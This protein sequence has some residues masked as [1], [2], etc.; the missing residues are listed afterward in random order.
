MEEYKNNTGGF[1]ANKIANDAISTPIDNMLSQIQKK[2]EVNSPS[3]DLQK[4]LYEIENTTSNASSYNYGTPVEPHNKPSFYEKNY[5]VDELYGRLAG[6]G[7][8]VKKFDTYTPNIDNYE[9]AAQNQSSGEKWA[10]GTLKF[11]S[12]T[13]NAVVGGTVGVVYGVGAF[14]GD[15]EVSSL[16][17]NDFS[18]K[19]ADLDTKLNYQLPNYYTKQENE[20]GVFSQMGTANFWSDKFLGGLS[21][22]VGAIVSEGIWAYATG[23]T[24]LATLGARAGA[25]LA[26]F[27]RWG[28]EGIGEAGVIAGMSKFKGAIGDL[29]TQ[30]LRAGAQSKSLAIAGGQAGE[31]LSTVGFM[32]RSAGYEASVEALQFKRESE[33]NFYRNFSSLNGREPNA[34]DI[35]LFE[36]DL[37]SSANAVFGVNIAIVGSSNLVTMGH[38]LDIKSPINTG[39]AKFID[40]KAFGYGI[41]KA[42][43]EVLE[44]STKQKIA[45][46]VFDYVVKPGFTEGLFEEGLQGVTTKTANKWIEH[47]YNPKYTSDNFDTMDAMY[48]AMGEQYGTEKGW[49]DNMLG[50]LIG[51]AGASVNVRSEQAAKAEELK[52]E[53]AVGKTFGT[54]LQAS[55]L[56][57]RVQTANR[58]A[59]FSNEAKEEGAKGNISKSALA[60]KS[61]IL[62]YINAEQTLGKST[63][64]IV[65]SME[66]SLNLITPSQWKEIGIEEGKIE[67][68]K[69]DRLTEL[70]SLATQWATNKKYTQYMLGRKLVGEQN[71]DSTLLEQSLGSNFS[72][73][74]QI[75]EALTWQM[76]IGENAHTQMRDAQSVFS[77]ELGTEYSKSLDLVSKLKRQTSNRQGQ[78]TKNSKIH[79]ELSE[80]RARITQEVAALDAKPKTTDQ[81]KPGLEPRVAL[82]QRLLKINAR[83]DTVTAEMNTIA[84]EMTKTDNYNKEVG[85]LDLSSQDLTGTIIS[86]KDLLDLD[87]NVAKFKSVLASF[88]ENNPQKSQYLNDLLDEYS[89]AEE[90]FLQS[91]VTQ[92]VLVDKAFKMANISSWIGS[93]VNGKKA[94]NENT[95][96]W[97]QDAIDTYSK[98]KAM[99]LA[100]EEEIST[101]V[102]VEEAVVDNTTAKNKTEKVEPKEI[103]S[104]VEIYKQKIED[105]LK[106]YDFGYIGNISDILSLE[107]PTQKDVAEYVRL[108]K[109]GKEA[110]TA[111]EKKLQNWKLLNSTMDSDNASIVET[112]K[113]I[114]QLEQEVERSNTKDEITPQDTEDFKNTLQGKNNINDYGLGINPLGSVTVQ[115]PQGTSVYRFSHLSAEFLANKVGEETIT[116]NNEEVP[117]NTKLNVGDIVVVAGV[118][119]TYLAQGKM[120]IT[121]NDY[122]VASSIF[123]IEVMDTKA[124]G[125]SYSDVYTVKGEDMVKLESSYTENIKPEK[126]YNSKPG[127]KLTLV[128]DNTDGFNSGKGVDALN[129]KIYLKDSEGNLIQVL[130]AH[131]KVEIGDKVEPQFLALRQQA[132]KTWVEAGKPKNMDLG[133]TVEVEDIFMGSPEMNI[134]NGEPTDMAISQEAAQKVEA[135][136]YILNGEITVNREI[137]DIDK[138]YVGKLSKNNSD[139]K[140]PI[141]IFKKGAYYVAFP[142]SMVKVVESKLSDLE[143]ILS[144]NL[145]VQEQVFKINDLIIKN[146]ITTPKVVFSDLNSDTKIED[147]KDAFENNT[148][149]K[150]ADELADTGYKTEDLTKDAL[151]KIDLANLDQTIKDV[152]VRFNVE[153]IRLKKTKK[154]VENLK[155]SLAEKASN[156]AD[157]LYKALNTT[158]GVE[159]MKDNRFIDIILDGY[160]TYKEGVKVKYFA[161]N[162]GAATIISKNGE[163]IYGEYQIGTDLA[164]R[165]GL[166]ILTEAYKHLFVESPNGRIISGLNKAGKE[167]VTQDMIEKVKEVFSAL[168]TLKVQEKE[169]EE[170]E[171]NIC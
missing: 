106:A 100:R 119:F 130:K 151:I 14:L 31:L 94:M 70:Q 165:R 147:L 66:K 10:N 18:N 99:S 39:L 168:E 170:G 32:G 84:E 13:L 80:E 135:T 137:A 155:I 49:K 17:D 55:L 120:E 158:K 52:Y 76:T 72:K 89:Q 34:E 105:A 16:Y 140:V 95:Q 53:V 96:E 117:S 92:R 60:Q 90:V 171:D 5:N 75:V 87:K 27:G 48:N 162:Q 81:N 19:L 62:T 131:R 118:P 146:G 46:N 12:K 65:S 20:E 161:P 125:W 163:K 35:S 93:K 44:A 50:I 21:F 98:Y 134:K 79:K 157:E 63:S 153:S 59:G 123:G 58:I 103:K 167:V 73:N 9:Y 51:I 54:T 104:Q 91:Q 77:R 2:A 143:S 68:E 47:T 136:G 150:T 109:A 145:T 43:G 160:T 40:R 26:R 29:S 7:E 154:E 101:E 37:E 127:D 124:V 148:T 97:L 133:I 152:K 113:L 111:V 88:Y 69:Q 144:S 108:R 23:G 45:R 128:V 156:L 28:V 74:A 159:A 141:V 86:G 56:G 42:T 15:G 22:T 8:Y 115:N 67:E 169:L 61:S 33:E 64:E 57:F 83:I 38:I 114:E 11:G 71:L 164:N 110:G 107:E 36:K 30:T 122:T 3:N 6:S 112:L 78:I 116:V 149:F 102:V 4:A 41:N 132:Y 139:K 126:A 24:S 25:K 85:D 166:N 82:T 138:T 142:I 129:F 121:F 1:N